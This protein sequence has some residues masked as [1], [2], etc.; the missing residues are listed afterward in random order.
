MDDESRRQF[1]PQQRGSCCI[2]FKTSRFCDKKCELAARLVIGRERSPL[3]I[4]K[5]ELIHDEIAEGN[6]VTDRGLSWHTMY[7]SGR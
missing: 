6:E 3:T 7:V 5:M 4:G 1:F 2:A